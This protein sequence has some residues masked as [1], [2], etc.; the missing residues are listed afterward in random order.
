MITQHI[1]FN[2]SGTFSSEMNEHKD[3][4]NEDIEN[5]YCTTSPPQNPLELEL[6]AWIIK[7]SPNEKII[8]EAIK[9]RIM[10]AVE[11]KMTYLDLSELN[12]IKLSNLSILQKLLP[13]LTNLNLQNNIITDI[14]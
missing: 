9:A 3:T 12:L 2:N 11:H 6:D 8:H 14:K 10:N 4:E 5:I 1:K 7:A 13:T